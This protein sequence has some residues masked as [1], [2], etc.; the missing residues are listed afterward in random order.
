MQTIPANIDKLK[1]YSS[2]SETVVIICQHGMRS[3][4]TA[5]YLKQNGIENVL[6]L[7]G[8]L[9]QWYADGKE[10]LVFNQGQE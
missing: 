8:G 7:Q 5:M 9:A 4:D 6:S 1:E 2:S 3:L 10:G